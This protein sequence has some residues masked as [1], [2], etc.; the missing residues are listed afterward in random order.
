V[1]VTMV[2]WSHAFGSVPIYLHSDHQPWVMRPDPLMQYFAGETVAPLPDA[3]D[4]QVVRLGGH[5]P[6]SADLC[7][8]RAPGGGARFTGDTIY[9]CDN[10]PRLEPGAS[11]VTRQPNGWPSLKAVPLPV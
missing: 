7:W 1:F 3:P 5:F 10:S 2:D 9:I 6:G 11:Q 4:I 8:P